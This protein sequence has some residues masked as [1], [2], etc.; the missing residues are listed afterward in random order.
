MTLDDVRRMLLRRAARYAKN[1]GSTGVRAWCGLHGVT[2]SH[3]FEFIN[4]IRNPT[5][6][7]LNALGLEWRVMRKIRR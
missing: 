1:K 7:L 5:T 6:D 2:T 4:H 3:A